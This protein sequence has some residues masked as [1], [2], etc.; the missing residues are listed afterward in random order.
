MIRKVTPDGII[1]TIAGGNYYQPGPI[2]VGFP[3]GVTVD[4]AGDLYVG[5]SRPQ[6]IRK[7]ILDPE[8]LLLG[9]VDLRQKTTSKH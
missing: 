8:R 9:D 5:E 7:I 6:T 1:R 2:N 4:A 3:S